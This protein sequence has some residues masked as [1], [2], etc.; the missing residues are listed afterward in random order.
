VKEKELVARLAALRAS[1]K[2]GEVFEQ[3]PTKAEF[4]DHCANTQIWFSM[5]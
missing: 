5:M 1:E 4:K 3:S 2:L